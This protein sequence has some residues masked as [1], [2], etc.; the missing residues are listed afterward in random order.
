MSMV[1]HLPDTGVLLVC[2]DLQ[3]N[4]GDFERMVELWEAEEDAILL[5]CGDLVHGP[6]DDVVADWP[7]HLDLTGMASFALVLASPEHLR[8]WEFDGTR[9]TGSEQRIAPT[10]AT[11]SQNRLWPRVPT[12]SARIASFASSG[13]F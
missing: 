6:S 4:L 10:I 11:I 8:V 3:G 2:T 1:T 13:F 7:A 5:F 12:C 9:L